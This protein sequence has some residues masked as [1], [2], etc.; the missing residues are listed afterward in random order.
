MKENGF[1]KF[2]K[3]LCVPYS[4]R[5]LALYTKAVV[6]ALL[7]SQLLIQLFRGEEPTFLLLLGGM[8]LLA[9][10]DIAA[11]RKKERLWV[12]HGITAVLLCACCVIFRQGYIGHFSVFFLL[13]FSFSSVLALGIVG[14]AGYNLLGFV[15]V[16]RCFQGTFLD[17]LYDQNMIL[18][19]PYLH[20]CIVGIAYIIMYSIQ[21]CWL[22]KQERSHTLQRRIQAET[23]KLAQMSLKVITA[24]YEALSSKVP[25]VDQHCEQV[26]AL[27]REMARLPVRTATTRACCMRWEPWACR[28]NC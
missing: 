22:E 18:R 5:N 11:T 1:Q 2:Y 9:G 21:S 19:Y 27:T 7:A 6:G 14:S 23:D 10:L 13:V 28:M 26:A 17:A 4:D 25:G 24:M 15:W 3:T 20:L 12:D 16:L 8:V